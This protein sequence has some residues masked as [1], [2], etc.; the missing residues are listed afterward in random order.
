MFTRREPIKPRHLWGGDDVKEM[1]HAIFVVMAQHLIPEQ[2]MDR[3]GKLVT[4]HVRADTRKGAVESVIP[5]PPAL[6]TENSKTSDET[7]EHLAL[8][9]ELDRIFKD[10]WLHQPLID[11]FVKTASNLTVTDLSNLVGVLA[12]E[13]NIVADIITPLQDRMESYSGEKQSRWLRR[14]NENHHRLW[15]GYCEDVKRVQGDKYVTPS[16][17]SVSRQSLSIIDGV[18]KYSA[19]WGCLT[20]EQENDLMTAVSAVYFESIFREEVASM[21]QSDDLDGREDNL[22]L[23]APSLVDHIIN[24]PEDMNSFLTHIRNPDVATEAQLVHLLRNEGST[25]LSGGAL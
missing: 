4:R 20:P 25:S 18:E 7:Q 5:A 15:V 14:L 24:H 9:G 3:T 2:R 11:S 12:A 6:Q 8:M 21:I 17:N 22:R 13:K 19:D 10:S 1:H 23:Q 16:R